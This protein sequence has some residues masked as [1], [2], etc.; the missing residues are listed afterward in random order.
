M[1]PSHDEEPADFTQYERQPTLPALLREYIRRT[2]RS[3]HEIAAASYVDVAYVH[4]L[5]TGGKCHPSRDTLIKVAV[6]GLGLAPH[7]L[8]EILLCA[9][10]APLFYMK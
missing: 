5:A 9:G 6:W 7:E 3:Y 10:L 2:R 4:R 1:L 8:D